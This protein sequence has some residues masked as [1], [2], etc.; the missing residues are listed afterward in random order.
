M[1]VAENR[2]WYQPECTGT[3]DGSLVGPSPRAFHVAVAIDC[4]MFI[5]GGRCGRK[6]FDPL[7]LLQLTVYVISHV[8]FP[9][10]IFMSNVVDI[11]RRLLIVLIK[12]FSR[13]ALIGSS[14]DTGTV[15]LMCKAI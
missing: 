3:E 5:F 10:F 9:Q 11:L 4:H 8:Q 7:T 1:L 6:R 2:V 15:S 12:A 14:I 13:I